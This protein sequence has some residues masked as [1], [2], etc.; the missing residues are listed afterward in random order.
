M[1]RV[2]VR[3]AL[4]WL[5]G[6]ARG[7]GRHVV[8]YVGC[9]LAAA[10]IALPLAA[11]R[12]VERAHFTDDLGT[13]PVEVTLT[14]NGHS[15]L[16]TGLLGRIYWARTGAYGFGA[17]ARLTGPPEAGGTLASYVDSKFLQTNTALINDPDVVVHAYSAKFVEALRNQLVL[18][19]LVAAIIGGAVLTAVIPWSRLRDVPRSHVVVAGALLVVVGTAVSGAVAVTLFREWPGSRPVT[20]DHPMPG[21]ARLSF[22]SPQTLEVAEQIQPFVAKNVERTEERTHRYEHLTQR[23]FARSL[24]QKIAALT[25]RPHETLVLAEADPQGSFV[26]IRVR[27]AIYE[28]LAEALGQDAVSLRTISGD[29]TSNGTVAEASYVEAEGKV[30]GDVPTAAAAGDHDS[31][32]TWKQLDDAGIEAP[33]LGT[34]EVGGLRVSVA[35]DREHKTLFGG[36]VT[37]PSGVTEQE[38]GARLREKVGDDARI[39]LLHQPDAVAGYLGLDNLDEVRELT[40]SRTTPIDDGIP[41]QPPGIVDIGHLHELDGP[42]VLWNTDG[43]EVTWTVVDQLGTAGGVENHPTFNRFSTPVSMPLKA[44]SMRLQY[45]DTRSQLMTGYATV[46]CD[47]KGRCSVSR[48]TDVGLPGG[49]PGRLTS[50]GRG[51]DQSPPRD[52]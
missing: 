49:L 4:A 26:G 17:R 12:A 38:L 3:R 10:V 13:L 7:H 21:L 6:L 14:H 33:D 40:A 35:N 28:E 18:V 15:Q 9:A 11:E 44:I 25:P 31:T 23:S 16:D 2:Q 22:G 48:R 42:W 47:V 30:S 34:R 43:N 29:I 24:R 39:V 51:P 19:E 1:K 50:A 8:A 5:R 46:V 32:V 20:G 45:V 36:M 37:N 27:S 52:R 41:D